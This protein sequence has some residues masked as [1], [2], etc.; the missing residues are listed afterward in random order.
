MKKNH[1]LNKFTVKSSISPLIEGVAIFAFFRGVFK[2]VSGLFLPIMF[3][4]KKTGF[5][6][7][8][9]YKIRSMSK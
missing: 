8:I 6:Y 1:K 4:I 2:G 5:K 7:L 3:C 9:S